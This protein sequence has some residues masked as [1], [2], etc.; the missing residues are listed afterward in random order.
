MMNDQQ[1][2]LLLEALHR[3]A[4]ALEEANERAGMRDMYPPQTVWLTAAPP[5]APP[6]SYPT[7][8][9]GYFCSRC[10]AW[11]MAGNSHACGNTW[12]GPSA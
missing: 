3:I 1:F 4:G 5:A 10:G 6:A 7:A 2:E 11:V 9:N 8:P 12:G